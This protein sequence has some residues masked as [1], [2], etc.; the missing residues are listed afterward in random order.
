[1]SNLY[2][3]K[4]K[5]IFKE[6]IWG[7]QKIR[8]VLGFDVSN[9]LNCGEMWLLSGL[10]DE[11]TVVE[12]G[13]LK[14]NTINELIEIYMGELVG[15]KV[16]DEYGEKFPLLVK[17]IDT[18][19]V[20]S[21][22]V[23]PD[24]VKA[25]KISGQESGKTE[26]W[27]V[28][29][30]SEDSEIVSGFNC[31]SNSEMLVSHLKN[32]TIGEILNFEKVKAGDMCFVPAGHIHAIGKGILLAEIQQS[33]DLTYRVYDWERVDV[34]GVRRDLHINEAIESLDYQKS[35]N[36]VF[37]CHPVNGHPL[38]LVDC[39]YFTTSLI[40]FS[41]K[42]ICDYSE[43]D[44]FVVYLCVEGS[45]KIIYNEGFTEVKQG[46]LVLIP[47]VIEFYELESSDNVRLLEVFVK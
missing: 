32:K 20:L 39:K 2:P 23:H 11:E 22:Q 9:I 41:G 31:E 37:S 36:T 43:I 7:G 17:I 4:F 18:D 8:T 26:M 34:S 30:S 12:N 46:E 42:F 44:S 40:E 33:S 1:M 35:E 3:L 21:L 28:M 25:E 14:D 45:F 10:E 27:Y 38:T 15:E 6:K 16:F 5:P 13:F 19:E 29:D 24:D 47:A